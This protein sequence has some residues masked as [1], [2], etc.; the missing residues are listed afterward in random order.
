M[1]QAAG[2]GHIAAEGV[3]VGVSAVTEVVAGPPTYCYVPA[4]NQILFLT[5]QPPSAGKVGFTW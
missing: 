5:K 1:H 2:A 3:A 4:D